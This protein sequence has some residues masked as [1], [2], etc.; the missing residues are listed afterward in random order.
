M[1]CPICLKPIIDGPVKDYWG[2]C[3][4]FYRDSEYEQI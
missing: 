2:S 3:Q 1:N 4:H